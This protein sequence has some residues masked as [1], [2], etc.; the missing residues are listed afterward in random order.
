MR[1]WPLRLLADTPE[2]SPVQVH[3]GAVEA[4]DANGESRSNPDELQ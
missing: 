3:F 1:T 4:I 2:L